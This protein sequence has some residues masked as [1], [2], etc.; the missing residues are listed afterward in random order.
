MLSK[1]F[2]KYSIFELIIIFLFLIGVGYLYI[3]FYY[4]DPNEWGLWSFAVTWGTRIIIPIVTFIILIVY[5]K[6]KIK[7]IEFSHIGLLLGSTFFIILICYPIANYFY[8]RATDMKNKLDQ[9]HPY[10]QLVPGDFIV[11]EPFKENQYRIICL[12]GSTTEFKDSTNTGWPRRV[13]EI[14]QRQYNNRNIK[15]YNQ[16]RQWYT[17]LHSLINYQVNL[18]Q[19]KPEVLIV[20]HTINDLLHNADF[21]YFSHG[22]FREDYGHFYGPVNRVI[23]RKGIEEFLWEKFKHSWYYK[24]RKIIDQ[25]KFPG[26]ISFERNLN[27]LIDLAEKDSTKIILMTQPSLYKKE[28]TNDL[29]A[30][31][32]M[33]NNEAIGPHSKWSYQSALNGFKTYNSIVRKVAKYRGVIL[34]DLEKV[35]PKTLAYF[36]DDVHY[37]YQTF[38]LVAKEVANRL[39]NNNIFK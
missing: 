27:T 12:G 36:Y 22:S 1:L 14:L 34:I 2:K 19:Y 33:L 32:Y 16:G 7:Q 21:S 37:K 13:E 29:K 17:T 20:M 5:H 9:Y 18:R 30:V 24:Q 31:L 4:P 6:I 15:V 23:R 8:N 10:L 38:D 28:T 35:I 3:G 26:A 39:I 25:T 11:D